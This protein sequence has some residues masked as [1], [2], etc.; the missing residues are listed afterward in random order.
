MMSNTDKLQELLDK[1]H[2]AASLADQL[3]LRLPE[4]YDLIDVV[5]DMVE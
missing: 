4:L 5:E 1:L 2:E 3:K